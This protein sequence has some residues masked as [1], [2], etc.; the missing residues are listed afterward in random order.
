MCNVS[1]HFYEYMLQHDT[2][3]NINSKTFSW[4][5]EKNKANP[6]KIPAKTCQILFAGINGTT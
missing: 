6:F 3:A 2:I 4:T 5:A 1:G